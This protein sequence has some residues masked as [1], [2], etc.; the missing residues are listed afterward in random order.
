MGRIVAG[1]VVLL[2]TLTAG[3]PD[4]QAQS[5]GTFRWQ[6]T[7]FCNIVS[8]NVRQ[9]GAVYTL[10]GFDNQCGATSQASLVGTAFLNPDGS[11]GF[12]LT[13]ATAPGAAPV[14][15]YARLDPGSVGG[16]W[17][18]SAGNSGTMVFTNAASGS[19]SPRQVPPNGIRPG[20]ITSNQI[21][22]GAIGSV[23]IAAGSIT[24]AQIAL[25]SITGAHIANGS[26]T[27]AQLAPGTVQPP[28]TG[29]CPVGQYLRGFTPAGAVICEPFFAPNV[30]TTADDVTNTVGLYT[31]I[32]VPADGRPVVSH[33]DSTAGALRVTKCGNPACSAGNVSLNVDDPANA[34]G[35]FSSLA[36]GTDGLPVI[37]Y[38][39]ATALALKVIKCGNA[40]CDTGNAIT[41]VDDLP[42]ADQVGLYTSIAIGTDGFPVISHTHV[43][44]AGNSL[45]VTH[46]GN[47]AC[48]SGNTS[49]TVDTAP[50]VRSGTWTSIAIGTDGLPIVSH[51]DDT[52]AGL[53]VTHC[54][55]VACTA[56]NVSTTVDDT[57]NQIGFTTGI[58]IGVDGLA[59]VSHLDNTAGDLRVTHCGNAA[60]TSGNVT[61]VADDSTNFVGAYTSI[62]IGTDGR[63]VISHADFSIAALRVTHCG[64]VACTSGNVSMVVDDPVDAVG[65]TTDLAFG[66]DGLPVISHYSSTVGGLRV[67]KC[68]SQGCR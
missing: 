58:A 20:S 22:A 25:G 53:R 41:T 27:A 21:A 48:S 62:G 15:L 45:R 68:A 35:P 56:S 23:Q 6:L 1:A 59:I 42:G 8:L 57:A 5:L 18:D 10:D 54:G 30:S 63:P 55:N 43:Y 7:P 11:I 31:S 52:V 33:L 12:G 37:S 47:A 40:A 13:G 32:A 19:G 24:A 26:I 67:T 4:G 36:I 14:V 46:C 64:N 9:D 28:I 51:R 44:P 38:Y 66:L 39:D 29:Q 49:T 16:A 17:S 60:C 50:G 3:V 34:V 61:T 2:A 65:Q